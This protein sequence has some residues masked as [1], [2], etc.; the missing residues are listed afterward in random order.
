MCRSH[1]QGDDRELKPQLWART[2][3]CIL[4]EEAVIVG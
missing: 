1:D 4:R 2:S 3:T